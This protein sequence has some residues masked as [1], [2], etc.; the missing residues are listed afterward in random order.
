MNRSTSIFVGLLIVFLSSWL[1]WVYGSYHQM[2]RLQ[3][4]VDDTTQD[5]TPAAYSGLA[6]QGRQVYAATAACTVTVSK[7]TPRRSTRTSHAVGASVGR[8][9]VTT[10]GTAPHI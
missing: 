8:C 2:G 9:H 1:V 7:S 3:V 10:C 5:Q 6:E 4:D